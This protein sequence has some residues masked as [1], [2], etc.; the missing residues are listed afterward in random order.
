MTDM[1]MNVDRSKDYI[2][3]L[4]LHKFIE[5]AERVSKMDDSVGSIEAIKREAG[6][7]IPPDWPWPKS[8]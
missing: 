4:T 6:E 8:F 3:A 5:F 7:F 1:E 2:F